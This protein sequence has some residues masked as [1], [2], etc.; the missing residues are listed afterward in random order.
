MHPLA[1]SF[2]SEQLSLALLATCKCKSII[3]QA[4]KEWEDQL[5]KDTKT[6]SKKKNFVNYFDS[7]LGIWPGAVARACNPCCLGG[8]GW[9]I[10]QEF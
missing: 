3:S 4:K 6:N 5:V 9:W 10:A 8:C 7:L 1:I 2:P